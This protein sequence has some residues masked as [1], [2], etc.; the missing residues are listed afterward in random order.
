MRVFI[1][2]ITIFIVFATKAQILQKPSAYDIA[3][4]PLWVQ[5]MYSPN[6]NV[7]KVDSLYSLYYKSHVFVKNYDT[8]YY[9]RWKRL[10]NGHID[11]SGSVILPSASKELQLASEMKN[12]RLQVKSQRFSA[13]SPI[14]PYVVK[15]NQDEAVSEQTNVYS[16]TQC[17]AFPSV[18]YIGTEPGE[19]YKSTNTG[20][21]WYC[22]SENVGITSGVGAIA[23]SEGN[24]DSVFAGCNSALYRSTD[25]G[26]T[27]TVILSVSNLNVMEILIHPDNPLIVLVAGSTGLYRSSDGG[28]SFIQIDTQPV[29]D[30]KMRPGT[31]NIFYVLRGNPSTEMAEFLLSTD[32]ANTFSVQSSGWYYSSDS[33]RNN[34]GGRL[35]VTTADSLRVYAYL[36]G[37]AKANDYGFIGV[38]RSD[39]G[40]ITW[41]LPN[42]PSGGPYTTAHPNLAYGTPGWTYHQGYY[43]CAIIAS[44][45]DADKILIGGLNCWRSND[46]ATTFSSVAG[47]IGGPLNMHVDMQ[48]FRE[49]PSGSWI[50]TDG[51][52]YYSSD[53][54]QT[55][56]LVL[57]QGIR[58]S[59]YWGYGQGWN[60]DFTVGGLYHNGVVSYYENYGTGTAIELGGGEPASGYANP[61]PGRKVL[62]S[63]V[64]GRCLPENIGDAIA[65]FSVA[66]FPNESYWVAQSSEM[67]WAPDCY[68]T[69][70]LGS[71]NILYKST[72]NGTS[73]VQLYA[74]G[75]NTSSKVQS[76][77]ISWSDPQIMYVSQ[78]PSS[79]STG[80]LFRTTDGGSSWAQLSIPS[81]NSSRIL[82]SL[83]PTNANKLYMAYP[84]GANGSKIFETDNGGSTWNNLTTTDLN[85]EEIRA[86]IFVPNASQSIYLFSYY[87]VFFRDSSM[88]NWNTDAA[89]LPDVVNTNSAKPFF[90]DGKLRLATYGKGIW[91][92][93]FNIQPNRPVAQIMVD[94][95]SSAP[96]CSV[97]TFFFD[98]HSILNHAGAS[99]QWTFENG[100][101]AS[102]SLRNPEV[103][104]PGPGTYLVTLIVTDSSGNNDIDSMEVTVNE[105]IPE[106]HIHEGFENGFLP[107]NWMSNAGSTGG[108][109]TLSTR[110]GGYGNSSNS[111]LFD[112]Y[113][114]DAQGSWSSIYAGWDLTNLDWN[115]LNFDVAYSSYGGQY[116]DT[117]EVLSSTD[118]GSTWQ[119]L[120]RKGGDELATVPSI[121][122][123]LFIPDAAQWRT[124][125]ADMSAFEGENNIIIA[126]RNIGHWGQGLYIDNIMLNGSTGVELFPV[127]NQ[128]S[129]FP[130][131]V[132]SGTKIFVSGQSGSMYTLIIFDANGKQIMLTPVAA[133]QSVSIGNIAPGNYFYKIFSDQYILNGKLIVVKPR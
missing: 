62:S 45:S 28:N 102:S 37:E 13:W 24:P 95:K 43:N 38:Y 112:N 107:G 26:L 53:F 50:T 91:E 19:I 48:D 9:K 6:P 61:G 106:T 97:D 20:G 71:D 25:G 129:L 15:N 111:A 122:D 117:L 109:W 1:F 76:I 77:E 127:T 74:F 2:L 115:F 11:D 79:G 32:T 125:S 98:D 132:E 36:I 83:D 93:A 65:G 63:E 27:W 68:N 51:G 52:V 59:E 126:F 10:I 100:T 49:T 75:T 64:G 82:L 89:G 5:E 86:M 44:N 23:V 87:N 46:G 124:D 99:W 4:S 72:D 7:Y 130:N 57:N 73:F 14:G 85:G 92:K 17:K 84:S 80:S 116:S 110:T 55:Q 18:L 103:T 8:Q 131:P 35:A 113:N 22:I 58:G 88:S 54:F 66:M 104:F 40:G 90:R 12:K 39:D 69:V 120:Y 114:Y 118:C 33:N 21:N 128:L 67:E 133:G 56:P 119:L 101:P 42:G 121:T 78:R 31:K 96:Y 41:T 30:I 16:F 70:F 47:Y 3:H 123:S 34:G 29:Y 108:N 60:E 105:Y 94:K 81:G